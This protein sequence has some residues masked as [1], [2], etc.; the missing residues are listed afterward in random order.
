MADKTP[1]QLD[2]ILLDLTDR[3]ESNLL[4]AL[5]IAGTDNT[6]A[7]IE[8]VSKIVSENCFLYS[9]RNGLHRRAF[10][11]MLEAPRTDIISVS[12][13]MHN[14]GILE[15]NDIAVMSHYIAEAITS[16]DCSYYADL[17]KHL[18][19]ERSGRTPIRFKGAI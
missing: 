10:R 13:T 8:A 12:T 18:A 17:V 7:A 14:Q 15:K 4:G 6:R 16:F 1:S 3:A 11:A 19:D 2:S 9:W 5:L